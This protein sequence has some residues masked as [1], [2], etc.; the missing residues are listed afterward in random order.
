MIFLI[1]SIHFFIGKSK[2]FFKNVKILSPNL[3]KILLNVN[4]YVNIPIIIPINKKILISPLLNLNIE[5][6]IIIPARTPK[7]I[8]SI[9]VTISGVLNTFLN[10]LKISNKIEMIIPTAINIKK[11]YI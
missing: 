4:K 3:I 5:Y 2:I 9:Y 11:Q 8:S 1:K 7:I 6:I 10:I